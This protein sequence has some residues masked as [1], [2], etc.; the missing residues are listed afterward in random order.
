MPKQLWPEDIAEVLSSH[1]FGEGNIKA[2]LSFA[3]PRGLSYFTV[4]CGDAKKAI[5]IRDYLV[6][7]NILPKFWVKTE[8]YYT[9]NATNYGKLQ[10]HIPRQLAERALTA[11]VAAA[12]D[13][14]GLLAQHE[15]IPYAAYLRS[16]E[17]PQE[18]VRPPA[19]PT[20]RDVYGM[21]AEQEPTF[22]PEITAVIERHMKSGKSLES[23]PEQLVPWFIP[24]QSPDAFMFYV[25]SDGKFA[26]AEG[27]ERQ[28]LVKE[29]EDRVTLRN[30]RLG[31]FDTMFNPGTGEIEKLPAGTVYKAI[32]SGNVESLGPATYW[33]P[34]TKRHHL[35]TEKEI[36]RVQAKPQLGREY[37][38]KL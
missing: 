38:L 11:I 17:T 30:R 31:D 15:T 10:I 1:I 9:P 7:K 37:A 4:D 36:E 19:A 27:D 20:Y 12:S 8:F 2:P 22:V 5:A 23:L 14:K 29:Y 6:D 21:Y 24:P 28:K 3:A 16:L 18:P 26:I 32:K 13:L 33:N 34:Q 25:N 35:L